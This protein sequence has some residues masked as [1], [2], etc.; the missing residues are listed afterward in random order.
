VLKLI[1]AYLKKGP[2]IAG[3]EVSRREGAPQGGPL[4]PLLANIYLDALDKELERR[5]HRFVRYADD[6]NIYVGSET[7][8]E[9]AS[10]S[11][12]QWIKRHL[13]LEINVDKSG[14]GR[15]WE[16]TFLGFRL[17]KLLLIVIGPEELERFKDEVRWHWRRRQSMTSTQLRD[18]W[19]EYVE[20]WWGYF[21]HAQDLWNLR[22]VESWTRRHIRKVF[23][24]RWHN[25][26]GRER[27]LR[28]LGV[29]MP[30]LR[31][32]RTSAGAW[33]MA[34]NGCMHKGL[35]DATLYKHGL[36]VPSWLRVGPKAAK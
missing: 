20:G 33:V 14:T 22:P 4:S 8:A 30:I 31:A 5:G 24:L 17:N 19:R 25:G 35:S 36:I 34:R 18:R 1:A 7:A 3:R 23:W 15:V 9:R 6:C 12:Q 16:R 29:T 2:L 13:R 27:E 10:Q 11:I 32:A 26:D 21:Q 28:K